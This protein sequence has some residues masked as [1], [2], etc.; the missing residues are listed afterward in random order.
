MLGMSPM[1]TGDDEPLEL[2]TEPSI[3]SFLEIKV[4]ASLNVA[5]ASMDKSI[6]CLDNH[7][8]VSKEHLPVSRIYLF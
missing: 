2:S 4:A 8:D 1:L 6:A 7:L 3:S 5:I